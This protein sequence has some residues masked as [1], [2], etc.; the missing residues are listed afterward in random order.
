MLIYRNK[1]RFFVEFCLVLAALMTFFNNL[2]DIDHL[3]TDNRWQFD[4]PLYLVPTVLR[5]NADRK[6]PNRYN[7]EDEIFGVAICVLA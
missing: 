2:S 3:W 4:D 7:A 1:F 6:K 5:G